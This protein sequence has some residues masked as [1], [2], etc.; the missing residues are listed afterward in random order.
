MQPSLPPNVM[1]M[2]VLQQMA[3]GLPDKTS[4]GAEE[5]S[6]RDAGVR[7]SEHLKRKR[8]PEEEQMQRVSGAHICSSKHG[9]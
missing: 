3:K 6:L 9:S 1:R 8:L 7:G 2:T 4:N 5:Y